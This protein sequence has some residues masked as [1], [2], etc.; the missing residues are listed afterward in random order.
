[1]ANTKDK[2]FSYE[3]NVPYAIT[4]APDDRLQKFRTVSRWAK[5]HQHY[6]Q[7]MYELDE[8]YRHEDTGKAGI[9]YELYQETSMPKQFKEGKAGRIHFHGIIIIKNYHTLRSF[10]TVGISR[11]SD[12]AYI[13]ID[14][15][16]DVQTWQTYCTKQQKLQNFPPIRNYNYSIMQRLIENTKD[17][18]D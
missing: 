18:S 16:D 3:I 10:L 6:R 8:E 2:P 13:D 5:L 4:I 14:T 12:H 9:I 17:D 1:M 11:L 15:I 7:V